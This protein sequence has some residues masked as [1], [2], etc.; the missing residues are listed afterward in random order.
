MVDVSQ[1]T[2]VPDVGR[3]FLQ[4]DDLLHAAEV[5]EHRAAHSYITAGR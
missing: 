3:V 5:L 2:Q 1:D 4:G